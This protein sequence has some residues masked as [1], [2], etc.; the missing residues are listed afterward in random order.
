MAKKR[1]LFKEQQL[2]KPI[3]GDIPASYNQIPDVYYIKVEN[4]PL[5]MVRS[6]KKL[7]AEF[8]DKKKE[9]EEFTKKEKISSKEIEDLVRLTRYYN[10]LD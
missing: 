4:G 3:E 6:I 7:I 10:S 9:L 1:V 2:G 8:P 5:L